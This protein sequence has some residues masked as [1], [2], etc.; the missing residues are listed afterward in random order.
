MAMTFERLPYRR[1]VL[2]TAEVVE[3]LTAPQMQDFHRYWYQ[4]DR[5]TAVAVGNLPEAELIQTVTASFEQA[6]ARRHPATDS[7]NP[8]P[9]VS[10]SAPEAPFPTIQRHHYTD[11]AS[12]QAR[13][14][15]SWR[16]PGL[17]DVEQTNALDVLTSILARGRLSRLVRDLREQQQLVTSIAASNMSYWQQGVFTIAASLPRENMEAV[18][19][20]IATH[21]QQLQE[22]PVT[23]AELQRVQTQ[24][25]NRYVF[26]SES[27]SDLAGLYGYYQTL[28]GQLH[29]AVHYPHEIQRLTPQDI[30]TA[31]QTYLST[32][33]YGAL[34]ILPE[35]RPDC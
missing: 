23:P 18:E 22:S 24:V 28:T 14:V 29:H 20:A 3:S 16:V 12:Q 35:V 27:P 10:R 34:Q 8:A 11:A 6:W 13:L 17:A 21:L 32:Q 30:Q 33:A 1:P 7:R 2:G 25:A 19:A 15:L 5:M 26:G 9:Q 4:P 31:A